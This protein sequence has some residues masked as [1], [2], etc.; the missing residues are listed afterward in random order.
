MTARRALA[1]CAAGAAA[2]TLYGSLVPFHFRAHTFGRAIEL[3]GKLLEE[4]VWVYSR[5][6]LLANVLLGG[7]LGFFLLGAARADREPSAKR[8][9][10][11][12]LALL[13]LCALFALGVEFAQQFTTTRNCALSDIVAQALGSALGMLAWAACGPALVSRIRALWAHTDPNPAARVLLAYLVLVFVVQTL[14]FDFS[15]SP[16][17]LYKKV[18]D[19]GATFVPFAEFRGAPDERRWELYGK[20][21]KLAGL[22]FPVGLLLARVNGRAA[23]WGGAKVA[24]AALAVALGTEGAQLFVRSRAPS[25]TDVL[26]GAFAVVA[27]WYAARVHSDGLAVPFAVSWFVVWCAALTPAYM[28]RA[29]EPKLDEPRAFEWVPFAAAETGDPMHVLEDFLTKLVLFGL[30]GVLVAARVLPP[31]VRRGPGGSVRAAV[32]IS[33]A[34][35]LLVSALIESAQRTTAAHTPGITDVL[36]GGAGAAL[37]ALAARASSARLIVVR[38]S[39]SHS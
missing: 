31:K 36:L 4:G 17:E 6:D 27:A 24:L 15:P 35:G 13:P 2:F 10:C 28:P 8:A 21:A 32:G 3:F 25:S 18:R 7:P 1:W 11:A 12:A 37:G 14:P 29:G 38:R 34:F 22:F 5:S 16:G 20:L 19:G 30:L 26:V 39:A 23:R 33:L 9:L